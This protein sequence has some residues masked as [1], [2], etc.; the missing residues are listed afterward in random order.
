MNNNQGN[1]GQSGIGGFGNFSGG[2]AGSAFSSQVGSAFGGAFPQGGSS[3]P[4]TRGRGGGVQATQ[5]GGRGR[6]NSH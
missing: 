2:G 4:N 3:T 5:R 1:F 6:G